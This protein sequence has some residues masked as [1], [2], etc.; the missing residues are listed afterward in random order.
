MSIFSRCFGYIPTPTIH[1]EDLR[2]CVNVARLLAARSRAH[3]LRVGAVVWHPKRRSIIGVGYNGTPAG[4]SNVMEVGNVTLDTVVH[5]EQNALLKCHHWDRIG[6]IMV[7]TH[8]P[9]VRCAEQMRD[10]GVRSV[11]YLENYRD[12]RGIHVLRDAKIA[13]H[14][15]LM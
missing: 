11:Y 10:A 1:P 2:F 6:G 5:A 4:A 15:V 7:I 13:V 8:S 9:C 14:R 3:R 12:P